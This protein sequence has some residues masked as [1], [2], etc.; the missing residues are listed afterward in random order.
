MAAPI[1][2]RPRKATRPRSG[3][4]SPVMPA[5]T[6]P[7]AVPVARSAAWPRTSAPPPRPRVPR[8]QRPARWRRQRPLR[9]RRIGCRGIRVSPASGDEE[10]GDR[11]GD[12][13]QEDHGQQPTVTATARL[14]GCRARA[15]GRRRARDRRRDLGDDDLH[16]C[17]RVALGDDRD[18]G[19]VAPDPGRVAHFGGHDVVRGRLDV[20]DRIRDGERDRQALVDRLDVDAERVARR[21]VDE[22]GDPVGGLRGLDAD[23]RDLAAHRALEDIRPEVEGDRD[24]GRVALGQDRH[25]VC[26][27]PRVIAVDDRRLDRVG[28]RTG[29]SRPRRGRAR[30]RP[31]RR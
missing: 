31:A 9:R 14:D 5:W 30:T 20:G 11:A 6:R 1:V 4:G 23:P 25:A 24:L 18:A 3:E 28:R 13:D 17:L 7:A 19:G 27:D 10:R 21:R 2:P 12:G 22:D 8:P 16:A 29:R 26:R 15:R